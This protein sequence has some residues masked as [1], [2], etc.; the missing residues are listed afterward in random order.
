MD[1]KH[2]IFISPH[3]DDV[4]LSCG[5]LVW[6]LTQQSHLVE[7]WTLMAG[8]PPD[9]PYSDLAKQNHLAWGMSG[10][11]AIRMRKAEDHAACE[12]LGAQARHFNWQDAIYRFDPASGDALVN[13]DES[14][15]SKQPE[16]KLVEEIFMMLE[17][18]IPG[19]AEL[20]L[21]MGIGNHIDHRAVSLAGEKLGRTDYFYVD[22]PYILENFDASH[23][24][25]GSWTKWPSVLNQEALKNWQDAVLCYASQLS[26]FW[27]D[28]AETRLALRNY[29]AG[30]GGRLWRSE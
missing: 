6:Y 29:L 17:K 21:P 26:A 25:E 27:R 5:G 9:G 4:A 14:L 30:G 1:T 8:L 28:K 7:V 2:W 3:F 13:S 19:E 20:V 15:F 18:E 12:V 24:K 10:E 16:A 23:F 11:R 22:Y